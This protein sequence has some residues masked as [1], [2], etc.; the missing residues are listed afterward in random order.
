MVIDI[1]WTASAKNKLLKIT[2]KLIHSIFI[3]YTR[4]LNAS[5]IF[6]NLQTIPKHHRITMGATSCAAYQLKRLP[7]VPLNRAIMLRSNIDHFL[8]S[9]TIWFE[10]LPT[11]T[12]AGRNWMNRSEFH[13]WFQ[14]IVFKWPPLSSTTGCCTRN[15]PTDQP[16]VAR[17]LI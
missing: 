13:N 8:Q 16:N 6:R 10:F 14:L 11:S 9:Y 5:F 15:Q 3:A 12:R 17:I 7:F 1:D 4:A 2:E